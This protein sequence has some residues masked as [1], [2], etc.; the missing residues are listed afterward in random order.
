MSTTDDKVNVGSLWLILVIGSVITLAIVI[1]LKVVYY[2]MLGKLETEVGAANNLS[3]LKELRRAQDA[4]INSY[5][6]VDLANGTVRLP[7]ELAMER[8]IAEHESAK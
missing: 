1:V 8:V 4:E 6:F 3:Q 7:I 2:D 5:G